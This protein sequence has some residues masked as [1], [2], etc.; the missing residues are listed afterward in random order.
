LARRYEPA[1]I[2]V[3]FARHRDAAEALVATSWAQDRIRRT[4]DELVRRGTLTGADVGGLAESLH[5]C[6]SG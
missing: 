4:A 6:R 2:G 1:L 5:R 3:E